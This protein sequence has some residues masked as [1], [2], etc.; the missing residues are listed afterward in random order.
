MMVTRYA[1]WF[2]LMV[3]ALVVGFSEHVEAQD[4]IRQFVPQDYILLD[5]TWGDLNTDGLPDL[6]LIIKATDPNK[7]VKAEYHEGKLDRN[8]R[9]VVVLLKQKTGF[10]K[11][12]ENRQCF[13]SENE[14]GGNYFAPDL[15]IDILNGKLLVLYSHGRY[16]Y[17]QYM[18]RQ[19]NKDLELIGFISSDGG[20]VIARETS[21]N[22]LTGKKKTM[23]NTNENAEGGDEVFETTWEKFTVKK[24]M[25]LSTISDFDLL[26]PNLKYPGYLED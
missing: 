25:T 23:V 22:F 13:S 5:S 8:R 16:G 18:F 10:R 15:S 24:R 21:M 12:L 6:V 11:L 17:R 14:D 19:K 26:W 7:V 2:T 1:S 20:P 9:G 4:S 3:L